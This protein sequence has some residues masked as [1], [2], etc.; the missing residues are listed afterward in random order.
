MYGIILLPLV[1]MRK[2][3]AESSE[4]VSQLLYGE[5]IKVLDQQNNWLYICNLADNYEGWVD[6][7][8]LKLLTKDQKAILLTLLL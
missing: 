5:T 1:P 6:N 8:M 7:K 3:A 2:S 4:L